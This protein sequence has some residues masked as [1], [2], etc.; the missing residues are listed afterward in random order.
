[1]PGILDRFEG[2]RGD[3]GK[4]HAVA[5]FCYG[6][7]RR[8]FY[9]NLRHWFRTERHYDRSRAVAER[10]EEL[11]RRTLTTPGWLA[12]PPAV[13]NDPLLAA[14]RAEAVAALHQALDGLD[15]ADRLLVESYAH[16]VPLTVTARRLG[17]S[18]DAAWRRLRK[19]LADL[20]AR[21]APWR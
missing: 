12:P 11:A 7:L 15:H 17:K 9:D 16:R 10:L 6:A 2:P 8:R 19:L 1:M 14:E 20:Q 3:D 13:R 21:L 18:Y 5:R 4:P